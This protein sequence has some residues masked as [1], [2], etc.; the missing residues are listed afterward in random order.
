[1]KHVERDGELWAIMGLGS[2]MKLGTLCLVTWKW[3]EIILDIEATY[4]ELSLDVS[5]SSTVVLVNRRK[6]GVNTVIRGFYHLRTR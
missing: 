2:E 1:M 6:N 3:R 5:T 4:D